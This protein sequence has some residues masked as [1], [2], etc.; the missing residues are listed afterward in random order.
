M[1]WTKEEKSSKG[2]GKGRQ[3]TYK[4]A[5]RS[6]VHDERLTEQLLVHRTGIP[7]CR[8]REL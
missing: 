5:E 8:S 6:N 3:M 4:S 1:G 2:G 7:E